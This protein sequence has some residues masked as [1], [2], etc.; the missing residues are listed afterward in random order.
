MIWI[1]IDEN[2]WPDEYIQILVKPKVDT[3]QMLKTFSAIKLF[4]NEKAALEEAKELKIKFNAKA[5]RIFYPE[6]DSKNIL[7]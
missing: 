6:G 2:P 7:L 3:Q 1:V 5:I 4:D